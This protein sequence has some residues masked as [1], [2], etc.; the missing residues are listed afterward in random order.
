MQDFDGAHLRG[1][2]LESKDNGFETKYLCAAEEFGRKSAE[3]ALL[4]ARVSTL[5]DE[6]SGYRIAHSDL[7]QKTREYEVRI[8][9][10]LFVSDIR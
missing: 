4:E 9:I 8:N 1:H 5:E 10:S 2:L 7:S 3:C 6:L